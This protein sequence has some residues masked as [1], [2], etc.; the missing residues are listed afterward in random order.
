MRQVLL[1]TNQALLA[2]LQGLR[3][4]NPATTKGSPI[5]ASTQV[6]K[7]GHDCQMSLVLSVRIT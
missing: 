5:K 3:N 7:A 4:L 2:V 1:Y 6:Q